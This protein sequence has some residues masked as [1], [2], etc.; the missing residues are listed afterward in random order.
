MTR[1]QL[2]PT[3]FSQKDMQ[4]MIPKQVSKVLD[5]K[6]QRAHGLPSKDDNVG[7]P[8]ARN[9]LS[10]TLPWKFILPQTPPYDEKSDPVDHIHKHI[11]SLI[12]RGVSEV[13]QYIYV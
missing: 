3:S 9:I 8:L 7:N 6:N 13:I 5:T 4:R 1:Q 12:G 2:A 10:T 11:L